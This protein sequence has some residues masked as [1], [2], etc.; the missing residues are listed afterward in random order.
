M[1]YPFYTEYD[2]LATKVN[3]VYGVYQLP[4]LF[5]RIGRNVDG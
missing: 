5:E 3:D 1:K 4:P 2:E